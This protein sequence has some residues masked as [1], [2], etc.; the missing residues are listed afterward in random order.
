LK[1]I[2]KNGTIIDVTADKLVKADILLEN[3]VI[4]EINSDI[5]INAENPPDRIID[6]NKM[7]I[8]PGLID[9]H[10]HLRDPGQT[11]KEDIKSGTNA[12]AAGGFTSI[13]CM[14]NT[15]PPI[16]NLET[17]NYI[18]NQIKRVKPKC[19]VLPVA[20]ITKE[21][22]GEELVDF[23]ALA[24]NGAV[25][26]SEDGRSVT[27]AALKASALQA[28]ADINKPILCHCEDENLTQNGN[29]RLAEELM[30]LRDIYIA[31]TLDAPI[32]IC[33]ISTAGSV[34]IIKTAKNDGVK[35]TAE[36]CPHYFSLTDDAIK[37]LGTNAKMNPPLRTESDRQA[38]ID[39]LKNDTIDC[40]VT[41][42]APHTQDEK[43]VDYAK[44]PN[45]I[46]GLETSLALSLTYLKD[47]MSIPNIIKK[48]T[49]NPAKILGISKNCGTIEVGKAADITIFDPNETWVVDVNNFHGKTT[50][51]PFNGEKLQG[52]VKYTI[53]GGEV[54]YE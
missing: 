13:A 24:K 17:L 54:V 40:I 30:I 10:V 50:N 34:D 23:I 45:G 27:N 28:C 1:I 9:M 29:T 37:T 4:K 18:N 21:Q 36:T 47:S 43:N 49:I 2:I 25:A 38:I 11:H 44:A 46:V 15:R 7:L 52:R 20:A 51:S 12:A 5:S 19:N 48:M 32:H 31:K 35:V 41:D 39:G 16:D 6:A 26:F 22:L 14:P 53:L 8:S 3:G 33:H 42:H